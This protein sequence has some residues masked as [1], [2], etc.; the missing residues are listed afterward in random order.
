MGGFI[1]SGGRTYVWSVTHRVCMGCIF[2]SFVRLFLLPMNQSSQHTHHAPFYTTHTARLPTHT[3]QV[4]KGRTQC[5]FKKTYGQ[6][7]T[8]AFHP[9][10]PFFFVATQVRSCSY[11]HGYICIYLNP[12][13]ARARST[14]ERPHDQQRPPTTYLHMPPQQTYNRRTCGC[15]TC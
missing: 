10:K 2:F 1:L 15:T 14:K 7:Q 5:P 8:L 13:V 11:Q 6:V 12:C 4:S 9:T 3:N